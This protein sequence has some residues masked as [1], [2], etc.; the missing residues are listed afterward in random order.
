VAA[1]GAVQPGVRL[2]EGLDEILA[3]ADG[4][5]TAR[6][7]AFARGQGVYATMLQL[8]RMQQAGLLAA[9]PSPAAGAD[10]REAGHPAAQD[11]TGSGLPR[12]GKSQP[13]MPQRGRPAGGN[14]ELPASGDLLQPRYGQ[15][16]TTSQVQ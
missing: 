12:R 4:R 7:L 6:D 8:A 2:G 16:M 10:S 1:A 5:R 3:L 13:R 9:V 14:Q 11:L 15:A